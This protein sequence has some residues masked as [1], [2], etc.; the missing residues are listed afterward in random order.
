MACVSF[1]SIVSL[2]NVQIDYYYDVVIYLIK[3]NHLL[4]ILCIVSQ[5]S[6]V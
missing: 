5:F 6:E 4:N 1:I 3:H 2:F